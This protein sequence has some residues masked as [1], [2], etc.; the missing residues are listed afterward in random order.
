MEWREEEK[1]RK[2]KKKKKREKYLYCWLIPHKKPSIIFWGKKLTFYFYWCNLHSWI[3][4][5]AEATEE[6]EVK[7][8]WK[9]LC[10]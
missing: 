2:E 4:E 7:I 8:L 9:T 3:L 10:F 6:K 1:K 5:T